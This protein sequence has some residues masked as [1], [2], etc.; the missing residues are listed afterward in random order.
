MYI[1][2][3]ILAV[4][5][6]NRNE[7]ADATSLLWEHLTAISPIKGQTTSVVTAN[8]KKNSE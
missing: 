6:K 3:K 1:S 2:I 7:R 5:L 8:F 4:P